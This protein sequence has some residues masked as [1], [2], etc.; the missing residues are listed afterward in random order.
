MKQHKD[1][2]SGDKPLA[3]DGFE[4]MVLQHIGWVYQMARR[5]LADG[6]FAEDAV[7]ATFLALWRRRKHVAAGNRPIGGWLVRATY[8]VCREIGKSER[9]RQC[10]ERK[11][12]IMRTEES[13]ISPETAPSNSAQLAALDSA[14]QKL[15]AG[16]RDMLVV[17]FFQNHTARQAAQQ[18]NISEAAAAKRTARAV[19]KLRGIMARQNVALDN[20]AIM[21]LLAEGAGNAP[22]GL[23]P[24]VLRVLTGHAPPNLTAGLAARS[25]SFHAAHVSVIAGIATAAVVI[26]AAAVTLPSVLRGPRTS[27]ESTL[28]QAAPSPPKHITIPLAAGVVLSPQGNPVPHVHVFLANRNTWALFCGLNTPP[29]PPPKFPAFF[30]SA[31][32][33]PF[34]AIKSTTTDADGNFTFPP[35]KRNYLL[36][37]NCLQGFAEVPAASFG[38]GPAQI[39][40]QPWCRVDV[41]IKLPTP[42]GI[43]YSV[44]ANPFQNRA[45]PSVSFS[46]GFFRTSPGHFTCSDIPDVGGLQVYAGRSKDGKASRNFF[47]RTTV[48]FLQPG[49]HAT[50]DFGGTGR[51]VAGKIVLPAILKSRPAPSRYVKARLV[52]PAIPYPQRWFHLNHAGKINWLVQWFRTPAGHAYQIAALSSFSAKLQSDGSFKMAAIPPGNYLLQ[53]V[54]TGLGEGQDADWPAPL[55]ATAFLDEP[56]TVHKP[57]GGFSGKAVDLG[58]LKPALIRNLNAG[59]IAPPFALHTLNGSVIRLSDLKG[60]VVL[61]YLWDWPAIAWH[62]VVDPQLPTLRLTEMPELLRVYKKFG[63]NPN[64]V[65]ISVATD[66]DRGLVQQYWHAAKIPWLQAAPLF[67]DRRSI[68]DDYSYA[69]FTTFSSVSSVIYLISS[70]GRISAR[71]PQGKQIIVTVR[72]YLAAIRQKQ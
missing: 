6:D 12:A 71:N 17:R 11:A 34:A 47:Y 32:G 68:L 25:I 43:T 44:G 65:M 42:P 8:Y 62:D 64:F 53:Y 13:D 30:R 55:A 22:D 50:V 36:I 4:M 14:M 67:P 66:N 27:L 72:R 63:K 69:S 57:P 20:T 24:Q 61:L 58:K 15:S 7:Q 18:F 2:S 40:L 5:Q 21:T 54:S 46:C 60:K 45:F 10:H 3:P 59:D 56:F 26:T 37:V 28:A 51:P 29:G 31:G 35:Q 9:R 52:L 33:H 41:T 1:N 48:L 16:D 19:G 70:D 49:Q 23:I 39:A 38:A